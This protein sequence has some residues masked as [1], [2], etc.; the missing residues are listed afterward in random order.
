MPVLAPSFFALIQGVADSSATRL[1]V[2]HSWLDTLANIAQ[3]LVSVLI[4]VMLVMGVLLL[5]ALRKSIDELSKLV[6]SANTPL[7]AAITEAREVTGEVRAIAASL[8]APLALAGETIEDA[9]D[10]VQDAMDVVEG[11]LTRFNAMIGIAQDEAEGAV[12]GAASL[13]RGVRASG[14]VVS[15]AL[16]L[17][18]R[19]RRKRRRMRDEGERPDR[20]EAPRRGRRGGTASLGGD[21]AEAP[22]I[23]SRAVAHS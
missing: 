18:R 21:D 23:R 15:D 17:S 9:S 16:G 12:V 22:R 2:E 10:R 14:S 6:R 11:R 7:Q 19:A 20:D 3:S 4:M 13:L 8:K 1:V 5:Y